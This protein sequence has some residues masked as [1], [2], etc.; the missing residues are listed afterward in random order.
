MSKEEFL[1]IKTC[2]LKVNIHCDGCRH[3]VKKILQKIDGVFTTKIEP[4]IGKVTVSGN[5]DPAVLIKKLTKAG[6]HAELWAASKVNNNQN[7]NNQFKNIQIDN[8]GKGGNNNQ[9]GQKQKGDGSGNNQPKGGGPHGQNQLQQMKGIQDLKLPQLK[10]LK[11]PSKVQNHANNN[12]KIAKF[13]P[14]D[15][16]EFSDEFDDEFDDEDD[17]DDEYDDDDDDM[18]DPVSKSLPPNIKM[19]PAMGPNPGQGNMPNMMMLNGMI[20]GNNPQFLNAMKAANSNGNNDAS[21]GGKKG[22]GGGGSG[23]LPVHGSGIAG[24]GNYN[25][26]QNQGSGKGGGK[27]NGASSG[28]MGNNKISYGGAPQNANASKKG[29]GGGG[30]QMMGGGLPPNMGVPNCMMNGMGGKDIPMGQM[31][32]LPAGQMGNF[33]AVQGLPAASMGKPGGG[34]DGYSTVAMAGNPYQLH[35]QQQQQQQYL[36]AV[37][38]QQQTMGNERFQPLMYARPPPAVNYMPPP[39]PPPAIDYML[40]P[41]P[42]MNP[43]PYPYPYSYPP[44]R[45]DPY[46]HYFSDEN[47]SSCNVM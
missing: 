7:L 18:D 39:H 17:F 6:K 34:G 36:A 23:A 33:T 10:E 14:E 44:S 45:G 43:Y 35:P 30:L 40:P 21:N 3:K 28:A 47:T 26:N 32:N 24:N 27:G 4:E 1:K 20:G 9:K 8:N 19:K 2:A 16:D 13:V 12:Q 5:I 31:G 29:S 41:H 22:N 25:G 42:N 37:M 46:T 38:N 11:L 15:D